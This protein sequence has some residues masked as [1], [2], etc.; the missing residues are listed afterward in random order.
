MGIPIRLGVLGL[1]TVGT[2]VARILHE[3]ADQVATRAGGPL[4]VAG[5]AVRDPAKPRAIKIPPG[6]IGAD[7]HSIIHDPSIPI[8]V[9]L[10]G[11]P[12]GSVEPART[13]I[14]EA[15]RLGKHVVTANKDV[16]AKHGPELLRTA[17]KYG[18]SLYFEAAV[19]GGIPIIKAMSEALV[20][21]RIRSIM[22]II[23]GTTNYMLTK[24][25][26][27]GSPFDEVLREAQAHGYAE[28]DPTSD[29][30]GYD[31]A[32]KLS[33]LAS[34]AFESE[35]PVKDVYTEGITRITPEDIKNAHELGYVIKLL[36]IAKRTGDH[37]EA[38]VHPTFIPQRHPLAA[39][40]DAFNAVYVE[41]DAVGDLMFYG[42]GAGMMPTASAV[43]ADI[44]DAAHNVRR[45]VRG[46]LHVNGAPVPIAPI[47]RTVS[48]YYI[49]TK[50]V[51]R[52][53]VLAGITTAFGENGVSLES[54][55]QKGRRS[56][57]VS[58]VFVTHEVQEA[59]LSRALA[60]IAHLPDV[61]SVANVIRV[62]GETDAGNH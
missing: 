16:V 29:V 42:R 58:L 6:L 41:G 51:D 7:P 2:G 38:R 57:P 20:G 11:C 35:V 53:G 28:S 31:A 59:N 33:I 25:S 8:V 54:V 55:I 18:G 22:G 23:N 5:I 48:R 34:I 46:R 17:K 37:V 26:Q 10:V 13:W 32:Y 62:E 3:S 4:E 1:G 49:N 15:L 40:N 19:A 14:L 52:P 9:E 47:E 12:G 27:Y 30:E 45:G 56:D 21:N 39:V 50:V 60:R 43:V 36:A 61:Y 44:V 24:M